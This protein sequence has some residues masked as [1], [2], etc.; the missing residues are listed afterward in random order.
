MARPRA[1]SLFRQM[2]FPHLH[3]IKFHGSKG[4]LDVAD[5][6]KAARSGSKRETLEALRDKIADSIQNCESGRD[7]AALSKRLMEI[8]RDIK[9]LPSEDDVNPVDAMAAFV[10]EYDEYEDPRFEDDD[11]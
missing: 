2:A 1:L 3:S 11:G 6:V 9:A 4:G 7:V 8:C 10:A 5:L